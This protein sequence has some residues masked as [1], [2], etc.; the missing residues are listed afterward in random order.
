MK[1]LAYPLALLLLTACNQAP[2]DNTNGKD[3]TIVVAADTVPLLRK[4]VRTEAVA[5]YSEK[6]P[7]E[8]NDWKFAV[9][10]YETKKTFQY[11]LRV[12]YKELRISDSLQL[13]DFGRLPKPGLRKG[14][15]PL[16]CLV[17]FFDNKDVFREYRL[18]AVKD[19]DRLKITTLNTYSV[20]SYR[21]KV[22]DK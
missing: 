12:Q 2:A 13:P 9:S 8:L 21:T 1:K 19:N 16:S 7:D 20:A 10:L 22:A 15:T 18:V 3:T 4:I 14:K 6:V 11:L 5:E 17:G